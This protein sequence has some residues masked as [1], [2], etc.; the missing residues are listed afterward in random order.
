M[1]I[2]NSQ[3]KVSRQVQMKTQIAQEDNHYMWTHTQK[4]K[5]NGN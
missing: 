1:Q 3:I 2:D 5:N 4:T